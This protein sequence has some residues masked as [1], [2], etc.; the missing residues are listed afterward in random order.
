MTFFMIKYD[1]AADTI[2]DPVAIWNGDNVV[3]TLSANFSVT[4]TGYPH[5]L[6]GTYSFFTS[7]TVEVWNERLY[8]Y[9]P[10]EGANN[11]LWG[12]YSETQFA[13]GDYLELAEAGL[14][15]GRQQPGY[16]GVGDPSNWCPLS[17][18]EDL[19]RVERF[20]EKTYAPDTVPQTIT[21]LG[22]HGSGL[23]AAGLIHHEPVHFRRGK[24]K[25]PTISLISPAVNV[26][27]VGNWWLPGVPGPIAVTV[28]NPGLNNFTV[29][30]PANAA[31]PQPLQGHFLADASL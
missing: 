13:V 19:K 18:E 25:L 31:S 9:A 28:A 2:P 11:L 12:L 4:T 24:P 26:P 27:M 6:T 5:P 8:V 10:F 23:E 15:S 1:G 7:G 14:Y 22:V 3:P 21:D 30:V 17:S 16:A 20:I 29:V